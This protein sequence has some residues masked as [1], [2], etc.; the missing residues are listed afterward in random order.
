[1]YSLQNIEF[2]FGE[3]NNGSQIKEIALAEERKKSVQLWRTDGWRSTAILPEL[4]AVNL[5]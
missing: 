5:L 2:N 3:K 4:L 1:L